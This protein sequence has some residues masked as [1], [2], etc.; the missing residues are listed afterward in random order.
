MKESLEVHKVSLFYYRDYIFIAVLLSFM[1]IFEELAFSKS[2][3][4]F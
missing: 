4:L 2:R 3:K 1:L